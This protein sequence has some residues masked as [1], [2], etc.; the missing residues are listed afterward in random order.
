MLKFLRDWWPLL[1]IITAFLIFVCWMIYDISRINTKKALEKEYC[2]I[3]IDKGY[4]PPSS[5]YK[6]HL[7]ERYWMIILDKDIHK[8]VRVHVTPACYYSNNLGSNVCF[9]LTG[10]EMEYYGNTDNF[11]HL[12]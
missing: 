3:V 5:G 6:T 4:D 10:G 2:G 8:A 9:I 1:L 11:E 12:K 7:E